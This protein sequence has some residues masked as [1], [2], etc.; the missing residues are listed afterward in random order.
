MAR[1]GRTVVV[2]LA[3]LVLAGLVVGAWALL[4]TRG[5]FAGP[6][7]HDFGDVAI[8]GEAGEDRH[9][10]T[11]R[12]RTGDVLEIEA[13]RTTCGCT[14][15][16]PSTRSIAPGDQVDIEVMLRLTHA[17]RKRSHVA[18][19]LRD[20]PVHR[21]WVD[22]VGVRRFGLWPQHEHVRI[23]P[24]SPVPFI[25][26]A[27]QLGDALPPAPPELSGPDGFESTFHGWELVEAAD[28]S[29]RTAHRWRA[30]VSLSIATA[31]E[32]ESPLVI[33]VPPGEPMTISLLPPLPEAAPP[34][35]P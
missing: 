1:A 14:V 25:L 35:L 31:I 10:F 16:E 11:L 5:P 29:R 28:P 27:E 19:F 12:N 3:L 2:L 6:T 9:V 7:G 21:L 22:A 33:T 20:R 13:V 32:G 26:I 23:T 24:E 34:D 30:H 15:A 8:E 18:I 17:G 4:R